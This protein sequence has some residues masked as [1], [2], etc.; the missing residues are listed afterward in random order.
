M[1][2]TITITSGKGGVGKTNISVNLALQLSRSNAK[3]CLFDADLGLANINILLKLNPQHTLD[4][5]ILGKIQLQQLI[6]PVSNNL[7]IIPGSS[8][9]EMMA[10]LT[11][12]QMRNLVQKL[13]ALDD[14]DYFIFDTSSGIS[15]NVIAFCLA[16]HKV[17]LII[18]PEPTSLTDAYALLKVLYLN[19]FEGQVQI[20]VNQA[21]SQGLARHTYDK[22][23]KVAQAYLDAEVPF[24]GSIQQDSK[25]TDAVRAQ[26]ALIELYPDSRAAKGIIDL[27]N[28]IIEQTDNSHSASMHDFWQRYLKLLNSPLTL[29]GSQQTTREPTSLQAINTDDNPQLQ[30]LFTLTQQM[31]DKIDNLQQEVISLRDELNE[32]KNTPP[33]KIE[34]IETTTVKKTP[35]PTLFDDFIKKYDIAS[36]S[37]K[38]DGHQQKLKRVGK[39]DLIISHHHA[40]EKHN[41]KTLMIQR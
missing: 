14:Y 12:Q 24:L 27:A 4:E 32:K 33:A 31:S 26:K 3:T 40:D 38:N 1:T 25:L 11:P 28:K 30:S 6:T 39:K 29:D 21:K 16:S 34:L 37:N 15:R 9:V 18:T 23:N 7:D 13:A 35:L 8:G 19:N 5:L 36:S 17:L 22:F 2:T 20:I 10:N 41:K